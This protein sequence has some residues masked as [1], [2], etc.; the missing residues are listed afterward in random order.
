MRQTLVVLMLATAA[1]APQPE[2]TA[3]WMPGSTARGAQIAQTRCGGCHA[4]DRGG[5][6]PHPSAP[7]FRD[8]SSR[9]PVADLQ[10]G[11]AEGLVTAHPDMPEFSFEPQ[12]VRD[13]IAYLETL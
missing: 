9:Y 12:E 13:L 4:V 11:L 3:A 5:V 1:C 8:L 7:A 6:S 2:P 10:E